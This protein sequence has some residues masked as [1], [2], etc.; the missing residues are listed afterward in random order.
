MSCRVYYPAISASQNATAD[1][2]GAP[3]AMIAFGHGFLAQNTYYTSYYEHLASRGY[4]VIAPQFVDTQHGQLA[5]DLLACLQWLR[6]EHTASN[7]FLRGLID[8]SAAGI[9]GHSMGGGASLL[10]ASYDSRIRIAAPITPA[11]TSPSAVSAMPNIFGAVCLIS[12]ASDGITQPA[13]N[14][15][16]MYNAASAFK[17]LPLLAGANHTRFMDNP[18][19]DWTDPNGSMTRPVQQLLARRYMTAAFDLFLKSDTCGWHYSYGTLALDSRVSLSVATK[20]LPPKPFMLLSPIF[21]EDSIPP[22]SLVFTWNR[23]RTLNPHDSVEYTLQLSAGS[24]FIPVYREHRTFDTTMTIP[25]VQYQDTSYWRVVARNSPSTA[26]ISSNIGF[27][28]FLNVPVELISFNARVRDNGVELMWITAR[29]TNNAGY[30]V[31]RSANRTDFVRIGFVPGSGSSARNT[32]YSYLDPHITEA[33]YRLKQVDYDGTYDYSPVIHTSSRS[34]SDFDIRALYPQ[35]YRVNDRQPLIVAV[36]SPCEDV[37]SLR[38]F[39]S[40]GRMVLSYHC[41][42][43]AGVQSVSLPF[44]DL[45]PGLYVVSLTTKGG[46]IANAKVLVTM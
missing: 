7:G 10:A 46:N 16:P 29:E 14:Q 12:G 17:S 45:A 44:R 37:A 41:T 22:S 43:H 40:F 26:T 34:V 11:E 2:T 35:P 5:L 27:F 21:L 28:R 39:N 31:E 20:Y 15:Q 33:W 32:I 3:Y 4:I 13:Q 9:S 36:A 23:A 19:G 6:G 18:I 25:R 30:E 24:R 8:T 38:L 1:S 42:L